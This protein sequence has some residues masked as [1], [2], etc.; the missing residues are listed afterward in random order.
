M[1]DLKSKKSL[2][3]YFSHTGENYTVDGIRNLEKGNTKVI[4]EMIGEITGADLF[5]V[6]TVENYP[7]NYKACTDVALKEKNQNARPELKKYLSDI[8]NYDVIYIGYPNW[9]GTMPMAMFSLLEKLDFSSKII[10]PFCTHEG[11]RMGNSE[12]DLKKICNGANV[13]KGLAIQGSLVQNSKKQV[14]DWINS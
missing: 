7:Y 6:E 8:N 5:E 4:A 2:V 11:S 10:K 12:H 9:W 13:L 3:I 1:E 14:E